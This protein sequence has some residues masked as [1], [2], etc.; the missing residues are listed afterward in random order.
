MLSDVVDFLSTGM[1]DLSIWGVVL[2][3][4]AL[5][6]LTI[7]S[8]T[9]YLHRAQA[10]RAIEVNYTLGFFFRLWLWLTTSMSTKEWVA[11]HRKHHAKCETEEDPHS[12]VVLGIK[13]VFTEGAELYRKESKTAETTTQYG[14][15]TQIGR[16][17][18]ELQSR[19]HS[20]CRLL[21]EKKKNPSTTPRFVLNHTI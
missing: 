6:H 1:L 2:A 20:V 9:L 14:H 11:V 3:T 15:G 21:L 7:I 12:P 19:G 8:V 4:L 13:K 16:D 18:S 5:T 17:T 10:H